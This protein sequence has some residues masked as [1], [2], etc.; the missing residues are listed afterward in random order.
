MARLVPN[1]QLKQEQEALKAQEKNGSQPRNLLVPL[2]T[3][4]VLAARVAGE[5]TALQQSLGQAERA[6]R[7]DLVAIAQDCGLDPAGFEKLKLADLSAKVR[8]A[9][10]Q[11]LVE[12][13]ARRT[14]VGGHSV[15]AKLLEAARA[16]L[17]GKD[18]KKG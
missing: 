14:A 2:T 3:E 7:A 16:L 17:G 9:V 5:S 12:L 4:Q 10:R 13:H 6:H 15:P 1:S 18:G 8:E 11:Q